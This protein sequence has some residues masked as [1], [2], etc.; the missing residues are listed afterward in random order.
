MHIGKLYYHCPD[1]PL[2]PQ[3]QE[4][5]G[6]YYYCGFAVDCWQVGILMFVLLTGQAPFDVTHYD[7]NYSRSN[8][9]NKQ[10]CLC[11]HPSLTWLHI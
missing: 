2:T 7:Y 5:N 9:Y 3:Q 10:Q 8:L 1:L 11:S 6:G 4:E